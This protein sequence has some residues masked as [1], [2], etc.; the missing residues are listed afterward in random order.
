MPIAARQPAYTARLPRGSWLAWRPG[1]DTWVAL[2]SVGAMWLVHLVAHRIEPVNPVVAES[3]LLFVGA[4]VLATL[5]PVWLVWH[6]M[7]RDLEDLGFTLRRVWLAV[8]LGAVIGL[9]S[10]PPFWN[11]AAAYGIDPVS[12]TWA[13][14]LGVWEPLF[15][16]GWLQLR[17]RD[18]LGELPAPLLAAVGYGLYHLG[19]EPLQDTMFRVV[20][21]L[22]FAIAFALTRN[23]LVLLPIGW[24]LATGL[25]GIAAG[26]AYGIDSIALRVVVVVLQAAIVVIAYRRHPGDLDPDLASTT[27]PDDRGAAELRARSDRARRRRG[28]AADR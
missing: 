26:E 24:G 16:Y 10:L 23:L 13:Q 27:A 3:L 14:L 4:I 20:F 15:V 5:L 17:L 12:Q 11:A 22:V 28:G 6:R 8:G 7:R 21:A 19:T 25:M 1:L 2:A 18:G 9:G